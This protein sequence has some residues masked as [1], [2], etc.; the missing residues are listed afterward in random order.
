MQAMLALHFLSSLCITTD[1]EVL[2]LGSISKSTESLLSPRE[3]DIRDCQF[4]ATVLR[5]L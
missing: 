4:L 5:Q 1:H 2:L 3:L